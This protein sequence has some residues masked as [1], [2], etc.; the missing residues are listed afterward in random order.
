MRTP[1]FLHLAPQTTKTPCVPIARGQ[2]LL[3]THYTCTSLYWA[4]A[5][6]PHAPKEILGCIKAGA[7][8]TRT[9]PSWS[10]K[11]TM[12]KVPELPSDET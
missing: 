5:L 12:E 3:S 6:L 7:D 8:A 1:E 10:D 4:G 9:P 11:K 2:R